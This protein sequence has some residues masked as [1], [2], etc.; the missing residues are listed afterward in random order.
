MKRMMADTLKT[1]GCWGEKT[2]NILPAEMDQ[3]RL[4]TKL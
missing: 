3:Q 4:E 2:K 1:E